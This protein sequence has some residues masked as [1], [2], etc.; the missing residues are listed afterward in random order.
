M[1]DARTRRPHAAV[2]IVAATLTAACTSTPQRAPTPSTAAPSWSVASPGATGPAP[3]GSGAASAAP[4]APATPTAASAVRQL[5]PGPGGGQTRASTP[6]GIWLVSG[7]GEL[8]LLDPSGSRIR[9]AYPFHGV[10][11]QWLLVTPTAVLCGRAGTAELPDAMVCRIDRATGE[12][13]VR[14][15]ADRRAEPVTR[16]QDVATRPGRWVI[17]LRT[18]GVDFGRPPRVRPT[19]L[20]FSGPGGRALLLDPDTLQVLGS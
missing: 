7:S 11:P 1:T 19:E 8:L 14:V 6:E 2:L 5:S 15:L 20:R 12:L 16:T 18:F 17:D 9:R 4:A 3:S 13:R 10:P